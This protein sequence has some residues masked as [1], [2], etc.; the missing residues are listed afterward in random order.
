[1]INSASFA[2]SVISVGI[3]I[4]R[5]QSPKQ[6]MVA[7]KHKK[8]SLSIMRLNLA[9]EFNCCTVETRQTHDGERDTPLQN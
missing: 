2:S 3:N 1:M 9:A 6:S 7:S 5:P 8:V 4:K